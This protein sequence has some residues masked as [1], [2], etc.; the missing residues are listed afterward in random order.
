MVEEEVKEAD[1]EEE[2]EVWRQ[3]SYK[4]DEE[5]KMTNWKTGKKLQE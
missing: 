5:Q 2:E 3:E 4:K 1:Y